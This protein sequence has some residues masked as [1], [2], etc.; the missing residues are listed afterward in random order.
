MTNGRAAAQ[1]LSHAESLS[2]TSQPFTWLFYRPPWSV[3]NCCK[4]IVYKTLRSKRKVHGWTPVLGLY[5]DISR[6]CL[7][8][9]IPKVTMNEN[10]VA[11]CCVDPRFNQDIRSRF[12][13]NG[14]VFG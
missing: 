9:N 6:N 14:F 10:N 8:T 12:V 13:A 4:E 5:A 11:P 2:Q 1:L 3:Q 7:S